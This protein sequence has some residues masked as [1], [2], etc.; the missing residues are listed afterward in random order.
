MYFLQAEK[1]HIGPGQRAVTQT[2][3]LPLWKFQSNLR[4]ISLYLLD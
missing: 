4:W 1:V 3:L 2:L